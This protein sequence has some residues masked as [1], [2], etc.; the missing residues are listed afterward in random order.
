LAQGIGFKEVGKLLSKQKIN[1]A[2]I[3][4]KESIGIGKT[5]SVDLFGY[6]FVGLGIKLLV[7]YGVALIFG[8]FMETVFFGQGLFLQ[9]GKLLGFD[10]PNGE[11]LPASLKQ[12]F[13][14]G[15]Q[16]FKYWDII[17]VVGIVLV[18]AE[19]LRYTSANRK[20]G[21]PSSPMT[22]GIFLLITIALTLTTVPELWKRIKGT[23]FNLESFR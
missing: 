4:T 15:Y 14:T 12:L 9:L 21:S 23:D 18:I 3:I 22:I 5:A 2:Q 16:G 20:V 19:F 10:I 1:P 17:K 7:Y 11:E 6:D 8:K 13:T